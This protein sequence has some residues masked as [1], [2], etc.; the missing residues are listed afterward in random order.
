MASI[1]PRTWTNQ[2]GRTS[3]AYVVDYL[4]RSGRR[5]TKQFKRKSQ[6][7]AFR[8]TARAEVRLG[9]HV[10]DRDSVTVREAVDVWLE[11]CE[12]GRGGREPV[13][14]ATLEGYRALVEAHVGPRLGDRRVTQLTA[15]AVVAYRDWLL[16]DSG[17]G[18]PTAQKAL[19]YLKSALDEALLRGHVGANCWSGVSLALGRSGAGQDEVEI[20]SRAEV[21]ALLSTARMLRDDPAGVLEWNKM[22]AAWRAHYEALGPQG[23]NQVQV[24]WVRYYPMTAAALW[25]GVRR[26]ELRAVFKEDLDLAG[27]VLRVRRSADRYNQINDTKSPAGRR[28]IELPK[29]L[30]DIL[31]EWLVSPARPA[32]CCFPRPQGRCRTRTTST[33]AAGGRCCAMPTAT[34]PSATGTPRC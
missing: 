12:L 18:R 27:R 22:D 6:A 17:L 1:R 20:P 29:L 21:D 2:S 24:A 34:T 28:T 4:D 3:K 11:S 9:V 25:T 16:K 14:P 30:V 15:P 26:S 5:R 8:D 33:A 32:S 10:P 31:R 19:Q 13:R 23:W 7:E